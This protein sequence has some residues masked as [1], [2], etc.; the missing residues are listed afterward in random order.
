M[1]CKIMLTR[2][3]MKAASSFGNNGDSSPWELQTTHESFNRQCV[4]ADGSG[5][6]TQPAIRHFFRAPPTCPKF[7]QKPPHERSSVHQPLDSSSRADDGA[8]KGLIAR[9]GYHATEDEQVGENAP[10]RVRAPWPISG[11]IALR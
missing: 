7:D 3:I 4:A 5:H 9:L 6:L 11:V 10:S 8:T 2:S 1:I